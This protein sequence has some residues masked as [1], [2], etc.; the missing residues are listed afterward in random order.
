MSKITTALASLILV[1]S[2]SMML[3]EEVS[4]NN[5]DWTNIKK[6]IGIK[7]SSGEGRKSYNDIDAAKEKSEDTRAYIKKQYGT[8]PDKKT[9]GQIEAERM[10]KYFTIGMAYKAVSDA[11]IQ[12]T[13]AT[14]TSGV[15]TTSTSETTAKRGNIGITLDGKIDLS[16][17]GF[18]VH[19]V[20]GN[21]DIFSDVLEV[22]IS[23][24]FYFSDDYY[25]SNGL[26]A[27]IGAGINYQIK[28][29]DVEQGDFGFNARIG[30]G[31]DYDSYS[32]KA[33]YKYYTNQDP[34]FQVNLGYKF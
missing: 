2:T 13:T 21:V 22:G 18:N 32:I 33:M 28:A 31:Y 7:D 20:Y 30:V 6:D 23:K 14:V 10:N 8:T 34:A 16:A 25:S 1:G 15:T 5:F 24:R 19:N 11:K 9:V 26:F 17:L 3:A 12:T 27:E 29:T 4:T